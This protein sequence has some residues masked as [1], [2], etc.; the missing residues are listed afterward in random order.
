MDVLEHVADDLA[1]LKEYVDKARPGTAFLI[2]VPAF[3]FLW[4]GH[5]DFWSTSD[6]TPCRR[7]KALPAAQA[8]TCARVPTTSRWCSPSLRPCALL[9]AAGE[10][11]RS[12]APS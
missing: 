12:S 4:S 5:D 9:S 8:R 3:Q 6:A 1:L 7:S 10:R 11:G 2:T